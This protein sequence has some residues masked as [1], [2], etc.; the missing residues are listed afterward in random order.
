VRSYAKVLLEYC[1]PLNEYLPLW[2]RITKQADVPRRTM[3]E[4]SDVHYREIARLQQYL[5]VIPA[6]LVATPLFL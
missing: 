3:V 6:Q 2:S 5:M 4:G 1:S